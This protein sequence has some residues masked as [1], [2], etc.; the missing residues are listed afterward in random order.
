MKKKYSFCSEASYLEHRYAT[1][2][3]EILRRLHASGKYEIAEFASYGKDGD[4]RI[5]DQFLGD[6]IQ[7]LPL[8]T[9][10]KAIEFME[11]S[12]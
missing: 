6:F 11:K 2:S 5:E 3:R 4:P 7:T 8:T 12:R 9:T 10:E 1:Y